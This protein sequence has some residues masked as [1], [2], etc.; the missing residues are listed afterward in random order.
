M[1]TGVRSEHTCAASTT[2]REIT[3]FLVRSLVDP[4]QAASAR[5]VHS[6]V[7]RARRYVAASRASIERRS[8]AH[9]K[10]PRCRYGKCRV[11]SIGGRDFES[12]AGI[13]AV[14]SNPCGWT[15]ARNFSRWNLTYP[16]VGAAY[17]WSEHCGA[18]HCLRSSYYRSAVDRYGYLA[19]AQ[20]D[21][22]GLAASVLSSAAPNTSRW[23]GPF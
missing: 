18:D 7:S 16:L 4:G 8:R 14:P 15:G 1:Q 5:V 17:L 9:R 13:S 2:L 20:P 10:G 19:S 11:C 3:L 23:R 6:G 12:S 22:I 21:S